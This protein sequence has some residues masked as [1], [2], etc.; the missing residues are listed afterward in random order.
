MR[1]LYLIDSVSAPGGA[2]RALVSVAPHYVTKGVEL[3]VAYLHDRNGLQEQLR[4]AGASQFCL[5]GKGGRAGWVWRFGR[6]I[7]E[8]RPELVHTTLFDADIV[9][10]TGAWIQ[11][12]PV[13]SSLVSLAYGQ[14]Q[15]PLDTVTRWKARAAHFVD[16][17]TCR[18]VVRFHAITEHVANVMSVRLRISRRHIDVIPR[19]RD[20][21]KLGQRTAERRARARAS[22]GVGPDT[23]LVFVAARHEHAKGLDLLLAACPLIFRALPTA[24]VFV[25]GREG[26]QTALLKALSVRLGL[27]KAVYFLGVRD[28]VPDLL[29]AADVVVVPSRWEGLGSVL[30]EAMALKVPIV[31]S[32]IPS[33][34][35]TLGPSNARFVH[36]EDPE[37]LARG[38]VETLMN[39]EG[40]QHRARAARLR[41]IERYTIDRIADQMLSFYDRALTAGHG[42]H[43][44]HSAA[45]HL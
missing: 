39:E 34:Q 2:E 10:R 36:P 28:D 42:V 18:G 29:C 44:L 22:M 32:D 15:L 7:R 20:P 19:G 6:L 24:R 17:A 30:I 1:L 16:S 12:A 5:A 45:A 35:E 21:S 13:V 41:F 14:E 8:R 33:V 38:I 4:S 26:N 27:E 31:A 11:R 40:A 25:A 43:G 3:D 9:G 37:S 23:Q